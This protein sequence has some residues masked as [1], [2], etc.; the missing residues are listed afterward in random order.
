MEKE[1]YLDLISETS[2]KVYPLLEK[3]VG[4]YASVDPSL[5]SDL[6]FLYEQRRGKKLLKPTLFRLAYELCGG[7]DFDSVKGLAAAFEALNIS[8][9]QANAAFDNKMGML[10]KEKKDCQ[11]IASMLSLEIARRLISSCA[12]SIPEATLLRIQKCLSISNLNIYKAQY[13]DLELLSEAHYDRYLASGELFDRDYHLRCFFGS[14]VFTGQTALAGAIA[15]NASPEQQE[16]LRQFGE[17]YGT[18]LHRINDFADFVPGPERCD[19]LYQ[20][21]YSDIRN[22][23]LTLPAYVLHKQ[24]KDQYDEI[25]SILQRTGGNEVSDRITQIICSTTIPAIVI[26]SAEK[27]YLAAKQALNIFDASVP[28]QMLFTLISVLKSNKFFHRV[29]V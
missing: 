5:Y 19:K 11:F 29:S 21:N 25:L 3:E 1:R 6:S 24:Y 16:A 14:G 17:I 4:E 22:G 28:K 10:D 15:A 20:D 26:E 27:A 2:A 9:Y 18:A 23:R 12:A 7:Q 8:S 13:Y